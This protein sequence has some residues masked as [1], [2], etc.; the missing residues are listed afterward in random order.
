MVEWAVVP[1]CL[2][3]KFR[4]LT[5]PWDMAAYLHGG[6]AGRWGVQ[7]LDKCPEGWGSSRLCE[8]QSQSL[9]CEGNRDELAPMTVLLLLMPCSVGENTSWAGTGWGEGTGPQKLQI[10]RNVA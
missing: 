6:S 3:Q 10:R 7:G 9:S 8:G 2:K 5:L 1:T 4:G